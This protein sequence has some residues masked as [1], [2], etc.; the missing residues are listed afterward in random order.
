M[1]FAELEILLSDVERAR[2]IYELAVSQPRL[3]MPELLWKSFIDF[4]SLKT[5]R[6]HQISLFENI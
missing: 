1:K 3:D 5:L 2:P 4:D 6:I